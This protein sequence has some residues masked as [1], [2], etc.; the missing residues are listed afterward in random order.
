[1]GEVG[2]KKI[3]IDQVQFE[4]LCGLQCTKEEITSWFM[5]SD[6][7]LERWCKATYGKNFAVVF[8]IKRQAGLISLRRSQWQLATKSAAMAIFLGKNYLG[9]TDHVEIADTTALDKLDEIIKEVRAN[10]VQS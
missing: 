8:E 5:C 9:Q 7:T 1:M 10:A 2:R 6:D 3:P 4:K